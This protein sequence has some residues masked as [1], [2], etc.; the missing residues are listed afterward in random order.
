MMRTVSVIACHV[1][2]TPDKNRCQPLLCKH[3]SSVKQEKTGNIALFITFDFRDVSCNTFGRSTGDCESQASPMTSRPKSRVR[4]NQTVLEIVQ[5]DITQQDTDAIVNAA[6]SSLLGGGGVDG[7]IHQAAG[8]QLLAETRTLGGCETGNAKISQGYKLSA[9][10]VI[11]AVGPIYR[12]GDQNVS[13]LLASAYRRNLE[14]ATEYELASIAFPAISTGVYGYPLEEA[15][16]IA[17]ETICDF[18]ADQGQ[19]RLVRFVLFTEQA[20]QYFTK[21]L[22]RLGKQRGDLAF[23]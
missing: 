3:K 21:T 13:Q 22:D 5:G 9:R 8:P 15:A 17:L 20:Y 6:N 23:L 11:H 1:I 4:I 7:A 18:V 14:I 12:S 10:Y 19:I 16:P 2:M